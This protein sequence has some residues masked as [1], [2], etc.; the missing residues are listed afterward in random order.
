MRAPTLGTSPT[1]NDAKRFVRVLT[2]W[3]GPGF[4]PDTDMSD[5]LAGDGTKTF[6]ASQSA[7]LNCDLDRARTVLDDAAIDICS[8]ALPVQRRILQS[9]TE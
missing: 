3:I 7:S 5:Y 9:R 6:T 4:H 8:V 1:L 2:R